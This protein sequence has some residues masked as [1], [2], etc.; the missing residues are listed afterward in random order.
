MQHCLMCICHFD[1]VVCKVKNSLSIFIQCFL[2]MIAA[3]GDRDSVRTSLLFSFLLF[4][5]KLFSLTPSFLLAYISPPSS[6]PYLPHC[7]SVFVPPLISFAICPIVLLF[8]FPLTY[9]LYL[10]LPWAVVLSSCST[11]ILLY[12]KK[13]DKLQ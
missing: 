9:S 6:L 8:H 7:L 11:R 1:F 2:F 3:W 5:R 10:F 12:Q 13:E 4:S